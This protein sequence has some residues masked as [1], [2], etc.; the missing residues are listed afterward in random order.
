MSKKRKRKPNRT[1]RQKRQAERA[2]LEFQALVEDTTA[3]YTCSHE[4][5]VDLLWQA[6][7]ALE[8]VEGDLF[9]NQLALDV[10]RGHGEKAPELIRAL[11]DLM[12][13]R[14]RHQAALSSLKVRFE[15]LQ[16]TDVHEHLEPEE[17]FYELVRE[18]MAELEPQNDV[19][20]G[21]S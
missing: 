3:T 18:R 13:E 14:Q 10:W 20:E 11:I 4:M 12:T 17:P 2:P 16:E 5:A 6:E 19:P 1:E 9:F 21:E 15:T 8:E 7:H